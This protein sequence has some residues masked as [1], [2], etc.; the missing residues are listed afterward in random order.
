LFSI[1]VAFEVNESAT[2]YVSA[3]ADIDGDGQTSKGD[4]V[5]MTAHPVLSHG[6]VNE[7]SIILSLVK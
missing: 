5:S 7:A 3:H 2:Y 4:W 1:P 6:N